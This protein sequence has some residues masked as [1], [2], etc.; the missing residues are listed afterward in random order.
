MKSQ[1]G[2]T[3]W[4]L[5][6]ALGEVFSTRVVLFGGDRV[7]APRILCRGAHAK[8]KGQDHAISH[9]TTAVVE[10]EKP[11]NFFESLKGAP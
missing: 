9:G 8:E 5:P 7:Q 4:G 11:H 6:G 1:H 10:S 2:V 3:F